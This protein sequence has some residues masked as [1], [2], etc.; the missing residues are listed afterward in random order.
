LTPAEQEAQRAEQEA[1]KA[2]Q[3]TQRA[4]QERRRADLAELELAKLRELLLSRGIDLNE[5]G[6]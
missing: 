3:E 6:A 4:D 2:E 5:S 1:Q